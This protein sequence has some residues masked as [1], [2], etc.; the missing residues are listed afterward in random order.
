MACIAACFDARFAL[1]L[2]LAS[3][4]PSP[5]ASLK[6]EHGHLIRL[7]PRD[8]SI[9]I[10]RTHIEAARLAPQFR[11]IT[12]RDFSL[13]ARSTLA[14][15]AS[16]SM[17]AGVLTNIILLFNTAAP[18]SPEV[19]A[20]GDVFC[21][22]LAWG[23]EDLYCLGPDFRKMVANEPYSVLWHITAKGDIHP[24]LPREK[25]PPS[26]GP[27]WK[28]AALGDAQLLCSGDALWLWHPGA[29]QLYRFTPATNELSSFA[30]NVNP[31]GRSRISIALWNDAP[32][33]LLPLRQRGDET[34][35]TPYALFAFSPRDRRWLTVSPS[36]LPRG[37]QL[38]AVE[39]GHALVWD[40]RGKGQLLRILLS[41]PAR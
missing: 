1:L 18:T 12:I 8:E 41:P 10:D 15:S 19:I 40:R 26:A 7:D 11:R 9:W 23:G 27:P 4:A 20:T 30:V 38:L 6:Y 24:A 2:L 13:N 39:S 17:G 22:H 32:L 25:F 37:A 36:L 34:F 14:V 35:T 28:S 31:A 33:A 5:A 16:A 3:V 21:E 29:A